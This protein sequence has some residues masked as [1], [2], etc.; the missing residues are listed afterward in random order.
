[1]RLLQH[2]V[3]PLL[4]LTGQRIQKCTKVGKKKVPTITRTLFLFIPMSIWTFE[5]NYSRSAISDCIDQKAPAIMTSIRP[6]L[7]DLLNHGISTI[8]II[9]DSPSLQYRNKC[10]FWLIQNFFAERKVEIKWI[11]LESGHGKGIPDRIGATVGKAT[12]NIL[13]HKPD[14]TIYTVDYLLQRVLQDHAPSI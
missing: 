10:M 12:K 9:S 4:K 7:E 5:K 1:M 6:A 8:N 3:L 13:V 2:L 14:D 11:Y